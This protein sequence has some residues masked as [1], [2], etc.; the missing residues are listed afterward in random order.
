VKRAIT[1]S[2][3]A[4]CQIESIA[5]WWRTNRSRVQAEQWREKLET[6]I[7]KL[8]DQADRY[9]K[10]LEPAI[11]GRDIREMLF[12][13]GGKATHRVL[14]TVSV[15]EVHIAAIYHVAQEIV[16]QIETEDDAV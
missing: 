1:F 8:F 11:G 5:R 16:D 10:C 7:A 15:T 9:P 2:I 6:A 12:G 13:V 14:F 4:S 3:R